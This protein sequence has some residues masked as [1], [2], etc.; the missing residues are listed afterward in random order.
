MQPEREDTLEARYAIK[1]CVKLGKNATLTYGL[2]QTAYGLTCMGR[3]SVF[4]WHKKFKGGRESTISEPFEVIVGTV[5]KIIHDEMNMRKICVKSVPR[6]LSDE[7]K[8]RRVSDSR[9]MVELINS[10]SRVLMA[11]VT[12]DES[13]I[14]C[15]DPEP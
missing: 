6:V 14:Y 15:C 1:F 3:A 4:R 13:W 9:E 2:L 8:E 10:D 5:H 12:C 11:L 7:Q